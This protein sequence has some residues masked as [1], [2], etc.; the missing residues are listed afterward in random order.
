MQHDL[1]ALTLKS[2]SRILY[3]D[4]S[5]DYKVAS[6]TCL[7]IALKVY[8][9]RTVETKTLANLSNGEI[10]V[11]DILFMECMV[12]KVLS[13]NL[14][15]PLSCNYIRSFYAFLPS[16][17]QNEIGQDF[18][19][20]ASYLTELTVM[21]LSFRILDQSTVAFAAVLH[22]LEIMDHHVADF[23]SSSEKDI[24]LSK[25]EFSLNGTLRSNSKV[26]RCKKMFHKLCNRCRYFQNQKDNMR[27]TI[28]ANDDTR[29]DSTSSHTCL[30]NQEI[31]TVY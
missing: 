1:E 22:S 16:R 29:D 5:F 25:I 13:F 31:R 30:W 7:F 21:E 9:H 3:S 14:C 20:L 24:F 27:K 12:L 26:A 17:A 19:K 18:I 15:P 2:Y 10:V 4:S 6:I 8:N 28:V 23:V 11:N